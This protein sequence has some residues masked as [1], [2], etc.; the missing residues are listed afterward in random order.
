V[1]LR[2]LPERER[3][4][5]LLQYQAAVDE[6]HQPVGY[7]RLQ[8]FLHAWSLRAIAVNQPGYYEELEKVSGGTADTVAIEQVIA[9]RY[10]VS[11]REA[12]RIWARKVTE[13]AERRQ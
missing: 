8:Q 9:D 7:R 11:L 4:F 1:I 3:E 5:F 13:A 12:E 2:R 10:G 6:A